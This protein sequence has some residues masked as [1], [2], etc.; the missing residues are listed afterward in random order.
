MVSSL[1]IIL[2]GPRADKLEY[3]YR[4]YAKIRISPFR[5]Q[6][7]AP[8]AIAKEERSSIILYVS[9]SPA[10]LGIDCPYLLSESRFDN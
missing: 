3:R 2:L 7:P 9:T 10:F 6:P 8:L 1:A 4:R 5:S